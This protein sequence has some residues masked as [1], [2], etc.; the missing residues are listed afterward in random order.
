MMTVEVPNIKV[1]MLM[2]TTKYLRQAGDWKGI[3]GGLDE[4]SGV[5]KDV[6]TRM[7]VCKD[8]QR[9]FGERARQN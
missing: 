2:P 3:G 8:G 7:E 6:D 9:T 4:R 5:G 1:M